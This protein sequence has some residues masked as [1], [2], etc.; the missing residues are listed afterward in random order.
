MRVEQ[1]EARAGVPEVEGHDLGPPGGVE[2]QHIQGVVP[3]DAG[4]DEAACGLVLAEGVRGRVRREEGE[5]RRET[6]HR[7]PRKH[8]WQRSVIDRRCCCSSEG[9]SPLLFR[10]Q[11]ATRSN[12]SKNFRVSQRKKGFALFSPGSNRI[13]PGGERKGSKK[14]NWGVWGVGTDF[15]VE[16]LRGTGGVDLLPRGLVQ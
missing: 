13:K 6:G 4:G 15:S 14:K 7:A 12:G 8:R 16:K 11:T 5:P 3:R 2:E 10:P 9:T 1:G